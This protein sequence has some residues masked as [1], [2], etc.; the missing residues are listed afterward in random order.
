VSVNREWQLGRRCFGGF[1]VAFA[2]FNIFWDSIHPQIHMGGIAIL[3]TCA[4][5]SAGS[6]VLSRT[7]RRRRLSAPSPLSAAVRSTSPPRR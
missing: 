3:I 6:V 4:A 1:L 2:A 7:R 5:A